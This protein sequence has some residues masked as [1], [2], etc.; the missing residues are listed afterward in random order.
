MSRKRVGSD[1]PPNLY[2]P[3]DRAGF[4]YRGEEW[5][6]WK[7]P[8]SEAI[9]E[10][11]R[12]NA[13]RGNNPNSVYRVIERYKARLD[14]RGHAETTLDEKLRILN[15]YQDALG[16][17]DWRGMTRLALRTRWEKLKPHAWAKHRTLWVDLF[18][19]AIAEGICN[20]NEAEMALPPTS[21]ELE[22]IRHRHTVDGYNTI[23]AAASEWL[24]IAME[25]ATASLQDR[26]TLV[27]AKRVDVA[28][29]RWVLTRSKTDAHLAIRIPPGSRLAAAVQRALA[30]PVVGNY[31]VRRPPQRRSQAL[32]EFTQVRG[33]LLSK[34]FAGAR[35]KAGAYAD[36]AIEQR[37]A[38]RDLRAF[39]SWLYLE[40]G[41]PIE[42]VQALMA[43]ESKKTT[44]MYQ[45]EHGIQYIEVEAG[46]S[47]NIQ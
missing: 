36:L 18:R 43:H 17:F 41:Y 7:F 37:P 24:Q 15:W 12:R 13:L 20:L 46:L 23:Y 27:R 1:L 25:L 8:E 38:F 22:R 3:S 26:S 30:H 19:F 9:A 31:L 10:A 34:A 33:N 29:G 42:Y 35:E 45:A 47:G 32:D 39:G 16:Q 44:A 21:A 4:R 11:I 6:T 2:R 14:R 40:A 28:G 5:E